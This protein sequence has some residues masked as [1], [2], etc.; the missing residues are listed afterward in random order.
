M[1]IDNQTNVQLL[2]DEYI[3][4]APTSILER[5]PTC[6]LKAVALNVSICGFRRCCGNL[7]LTFHV[8]SMMIEDVDSYDEGYSSGNIMAIL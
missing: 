5:W 3:S 7:E 1:K 8:K 4:M 2:R 6:C